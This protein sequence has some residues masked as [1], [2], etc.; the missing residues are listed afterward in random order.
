MGQFARIVR[1]QPQ[2]LPAQAQVQIP[3]QALLAPIVKPLHGSP[4]ALWLLP[5]RRNEDGV[6][7]ILTGGFQQDQGVA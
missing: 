7:L 6:D 2:A 4:A 5:W 1:S 3:A